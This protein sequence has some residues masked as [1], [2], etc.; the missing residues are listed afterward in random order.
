MVLLYPLVT[1]FTIQ[2]RLRPS[3]GPR[4]HV[5]FMADEATTEARTPFRIFQDHNLERISESDRQGINNL[6]EDVQAMKVLQPIISWSEVQRLAST[7][8]STPDERCQFARIFSS[9]GSFLLLELN[10]TQASVVDD[11]WE[12]MQMFFDQVEE[13]D[14]HHQTLAREGDAHENVGYKFVQTYNTPGDVVLPTTIQDALGQDPTTH[15]SA[16]DSFLFF[17]EIAAT[18]ATVV[19]AGALKED[20]QIMKSVVDGL[21]HSSSTRFA[22]ANQRL[23]RYVL[24]DSE[25]GPL[26]ESLRAHTDWTFTTPIPLSATPGLHLWKP[27]S[28]QWV[29]PE[30]LVRDLPLARTRY[31][32]V[33]AGKWMELLTNQ[34]VLA[35]I[36]RVVSQTSQEARLS[37]P[38]FL[39]PK[40]VV[41]E[42]LSG[43][44]NNPHHTSPTMS[45]EEATNEIHKMFQGFIEMTKGAKHA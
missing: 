21:L 1:C 4:T 22:S 44:F 40:E 6:A 32:V 11:M 10:E 5:R 9:A 38:F 19:S 45:T 31:L 27:D 34:V 15:R 26:K 43:E 23:S 29:A 8:D 37:A 28:E 35:C 2:I 30:S 39:R 17:A 33:M 3:F 14:L 25:T 12:S 20:P 36:H 41:F 13:G 18:V 16:S 24:T 42:S 7:W